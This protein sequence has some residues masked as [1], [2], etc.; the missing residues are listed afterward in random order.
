M[1]GAEDFASDK[2]TWMLEFDELI[3]RIG[4]VSQGGNSVE[5]VKREKKDGLQGECDH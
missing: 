4:Q 3:R 5:D 2:G 1:K